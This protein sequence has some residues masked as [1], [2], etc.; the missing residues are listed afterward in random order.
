MCPGSS[1]L[2]GGL[3]LA[4]TLLGMTD[5]ASTSP[6][7][8]SYLDR[9]SVTTLLPALAEQLDLVEETYVAMAQGR[10]ELPPKQ[11]IHPRT[12][13]FIHAMPAYLMNRD[14]AAIKWVSAY[15]QNPS[16]GLPYISGLIIVNDPE[17]GLPQVIMDAGAITAIRTAV[18]SGVSIRHLAHKGWSRV[19][20]LG[21]GE[22]GRSHARVVSSL[23]PDAEIRVYG[24]R[25]TGPVEG[26]TVAPDARSAVEGA[27]VVITCSPMSKKPTPVLDRSWLTDRCLVVPVDFDAYV[28]PSLVHGA[29]QFV[30]D[31]V[32]Q[33]ELFRARGSFAGWPEAT[34]SIG[35]ALQ[36][37]PH[38][39]LRVVCNLGVGS[40]DAA[41]AGVVLERELAA[42]IGVQLPR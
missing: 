31:D 12:D 27:D 1:A 36:A 17:T 3:G 13:A 40:I 4:A 23:N 11:G 35:E 25:L 19:A 6:S 16:K 37:E 22:Q 33:Y 8:I 42:P 28:I 18:G 5:D 29:E 34:V 20:I 26:V 24:P 39:N 14:V 32:A 21:F 10:V 41:L 2:V 9:S 7:T 38:G 30:V 15:P